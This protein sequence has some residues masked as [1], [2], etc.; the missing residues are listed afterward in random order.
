MV[1]A[2]YNAIYQCADATWF[3]RLKG[4]ALLFWNWGPE[5]QQEVSNGQPHFMMGSP[6]TIHK[7]AVQN[8]GPPEAGADASKGG[9]SV[10]AEEP[11]K[12]VRGRQWDTLFLCRQGGL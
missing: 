8:K 6:E 3:E 11:H 1:E 4:S 7:E 12:A 9:T 2:G 5:Y 10:S